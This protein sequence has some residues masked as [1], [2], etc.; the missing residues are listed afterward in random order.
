MARADINE[1]NPSSARHRTGMAIIPLKVTVR[2]GSKSIITYAYLDNGSNFSF[3]TESLALQLGLKG[4]RTKISSS[5]LEKKN[6]TVDTVVSS[7][8][9][10]LCLTLMRMSISAY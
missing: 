7:F 5:T 10:S 8:T 2:G 6:S 4:Q 9:I 3:C 1:E